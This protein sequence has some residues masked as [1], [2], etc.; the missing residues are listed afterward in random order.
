LRGGKALIDKSNEF[1]DSAND[2][3]AGVGNPGRTGAPPVLPS[4]SLG[5][6]APVFGNSKIK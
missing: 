3:L 1:I 5:F 4:A 2:A 6:L